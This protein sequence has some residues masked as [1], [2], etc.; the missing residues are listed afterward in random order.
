MPVKAKA[1]N[2]FSLCYAPR[3]PSPFSSRPVFYLTFLLPMH[4]LKPLLSRTSLTILTFQPIFVLADSIPT[5]LGS[6]SALLWGSPCLHLLPLVRR[7]QP[8][9]PIQPHLSSAS[10]LLSHML[11]WTALAPD[12]CT[13]LLGT[14]ALRDSFP[15]DSADQVP[16]QTEF[17][18]LKLRAI[19]LL[20]TF[21]T[22]FR[23]LIDRSD[24]PI[25]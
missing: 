14:F 6:A 19:I 10:S 12:D 11:G 7:A 15:W 9:P 8:G 20:L 1:R 22:S 13:G 18:S 24:L 5:H 21:L 16:E 17:F 3:L 25:S 2:G 23:I 4:L